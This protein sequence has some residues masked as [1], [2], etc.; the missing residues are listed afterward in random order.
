[1]SRRRIGI[2]TFVD[3]DQRLDQRFRNVAA[4]GT[5]SGLLLSIPAKSKE[6]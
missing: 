1:M 3:R 5:T 6:K 2:H 4:A